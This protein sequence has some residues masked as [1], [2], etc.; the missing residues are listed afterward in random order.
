MFKNLQFSALFVLVASFYASFN[1]FL[2]FATFCEFFLRS[3]LRSGGFGVS[4]IMIHDHSY[5]D[6][7]ALSELDTTLRFL[8]AGIAGRK[9]FC[10]TPT[11]GKGVGLLFTDE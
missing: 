6:Y 4:D 9:G 2:V 3:S 1:S 8:P 7:L 10:L 5:Q 11:R